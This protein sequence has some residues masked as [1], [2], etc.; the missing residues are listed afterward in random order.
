MAQP[1]PNTMAVIVNPPVHTVTETA[2]GGTDPY[3]DNSAAG[4]FS[5]IST[6]SKLVITAPLSE[7]PLMVTAGAGFGSQD[8]PGLS[9]S[10]EDQ[11]GNVVVNDSKPVLISVASGPP[12]EVLSGVLSADAVN[13]VATFNGLSLNKAG[14]AVL[15]LSRHGLTSALTTKIL[16]TPAQAAQLVITQAANQYVVADGDLSSH[17]SVGRRPVRQSGDGR[18]HDPDIGVAGHR[19]RP[20]P[21]SDQRHGRQRRGHLLVDAG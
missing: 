21:G 8:G 17:S 18:Q 7:P 14:T 6:P 12:G 2:S 20:A 15:T 3:A 4:A 9:V 1:G 13:G 10:V 5:G 11:F 19:R 16:V